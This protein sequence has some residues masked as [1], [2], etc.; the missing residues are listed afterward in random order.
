MLLLEFLDPIG[1]NE[2]IHQKLGRFC[3]LSCQRETSLLQLED[4][5]SSEYLADNGRA[6]FKSRI[7]PKLSLLQIAISRHFEHQDSRSLEAVS[8]T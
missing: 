7:P 6:V 2:I 8:I 3:H 4:H 5:E 1:E